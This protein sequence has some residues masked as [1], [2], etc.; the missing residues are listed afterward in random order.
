MPTTSA[1][2]WRAPMN[3]TECRQYWPSDWPHRAPSTRP[4]KS[5]RRHG[6]K[7]MG[8]GTQAHLSAAARGATTLVLAARLAQQAEARGR[9]SS[10][11]ATSG[12]APCGYKIAASMVKIAE[13]ALGGEYTVTVNPYPSTT[14]AMKATMD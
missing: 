13:E 3:C 4:M 14:G 8:S 2:A 11:W 10:R 7:E 6:G 9:E 1:V 12:G 5:R